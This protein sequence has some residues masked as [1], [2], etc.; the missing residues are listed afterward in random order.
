MYETGVATH[1]SGLEEEVTNL[2]AEIT[3]DGVHDTEWIVGMAAA[4][5]RAWQTAQ[6][7]PSVGAV[8]MFYDIE[9]S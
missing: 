9:T 3:Q 1:L 4:A 8:E 7:A 5:S 6:P 2:L